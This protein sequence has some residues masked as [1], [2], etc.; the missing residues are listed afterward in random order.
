MKKVLIVSLTPCYPL[1][2]GGALGQYFFI[3]GLKNRVKFVFCTE[4]TSAQGLKDIQLLQEKQPQLQIYYVDKSAGGKVRKSLFFYLKK[5]LFGLIKTCRRFTKRSKEQSPTSSD[6]FDDPYFWHIDHPHSPEL[7]AL[8]NEVIVKENITQVQ[9]DYY[10]TIDLCFAVPDYIRKIYVNHEVRYRRLE[11]A[12]ESSPK[13]EAYKKYLIQKTETF[14]RV[15]I[16]RADEVVFVN[17]FDAT[18]FES[19]ARKV[20]FSPPS[21]P[22]ELITKTDVSNS[23]SRLLFMGSEGHT[24]NK[25]GLKWFLD[26]IYLPNR[27]EIKYPLYVTGEWSDAFKA[28]YNDFSEVIF[29]GLVPSLSPYYE[30]SVLINPILTGAG[31]RTK[32]LQSFANKIP[33]LSTPFGAEGCFDSTESS[34]VGLFTDAAGFMEI[35]RSVDF[36]SLGLAGYQYLSN[37]YNKELLLNKRYDIYN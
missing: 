30:H 15:C 34:H 24:P 9:F 23:F 3:D 32:I 18:L 31:V 21:I 12:F 20:T 13:P 37:K 5:I 35:I 1:T 19:D 25:L 14:E 16:A 36:R 33:V 2:H 27:A 10:E 29:V 11:L 17:E 4:V 6:D 7:V 28:E 8:V 22:D 26:H